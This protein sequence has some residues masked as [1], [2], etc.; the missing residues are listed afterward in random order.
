MTLRLRLF[1]SLQIEPDPGIGRLALRPRAQRLLVYLLLHRH[2][3]LRREQVAFALWPDHPEDESLGTLR[4]A[5]SD[6]RSGFPP[7]TPGDW[8]AVAHGQLRWNA[9]TEYW[10]DVECFTQ[11]IGQATPAA[12]HDA[13]ALYSGDLLTD[14][15]EEWVV[16]ERERLRQ[17]YINALRQLAAHH[18]SLGSNERALDFARRALAY[19]PLSEPLSRDLM[20]L[21]YETGDRTAALAVYERLRGLLYDELAIDPLPETQA[22]H[23]AILQ[24]APVVDREL[25]SAELAR[26]RAPPQPTPQPIG[27]GAEMQT[28]AALWQRAT[29]GAGCFALVSGA[30]GIGK[31][32]L[33]HSLADHARQGGGLALV[34]YNLNFEQ[35]LPYQPIVGMLRMAGAMLHHVELAPAHRAALG[36][37]APDILGI[38]A[39]PAPPADRA[40]HDELR[41][42]LFEALLQAFLGLARAQPLLLVFEDI[43]WAEASTIDWL[44]YVTPHLHGSRLM[45]LVT[46]RTEEVGSSH[47]LAQLQARFDPQAPITTMPLPP[48][49]REAHRDL[50]AHLSGLDRPQATAVADCLFQQSAGNP[51]FLRELVRGLL[52]TGQI[53]ARQERWSGPLIDNPTG[54]HCPVPD[55]LRTLITA[56][57]ERLNEMSRM[58]LRTAAVAGR[59]FDYELV[60]RT[61]GWAD[62]HALGALDDL[63]AREFIR[64]SE[65]PG[66][67]AFGHHLVRD[68]IYG[69]LTV[70]RR[71]YLHRR[72]AES[73]LALQPDNVAALAYHFAEGGESA[74]AGLYYLRAGDQARQFLALP[75][76][77]EYYRA[78][79]KHWPDADELG[80]AKTLVKL[81]H[82]HWVLMATR[83]A[84]DSF[85]AARIIFETRGDL[86][87]QVMVGDIERMM[88]RIYWELGDAE[89]AWAH[90][91]R[92]YALLE[93]AGE[94]VELAHTISSISQM[95][96]IASRFAEAISWGERALALAE[97]LGAEGVRI[98]ALNNV[99]YSIMFVSDR[100]VERGLVML[101]ESLRHALAADLVP[102]AC[103]ACQNLGDA[104]RGLCRY[105]EARATLDSLNAYAA[106]F[107]VPRFVGVSLCLRLGIDWITGDWS[108]A[109]SSLAATNVMYGSPAVWLSTRRGQIENDLGRAETARQELERTLPTVRGMDELQTTMPH[110]GELVRAYAALELEAQAAEIAQQILALIDRHPSL[111]PDSTR[112]LLIVCRWGAANPAAQVARDALRHL[113]RADQQF[114]SPETAAALA[115]ARGAPALAGGAW[116]DAIEQFRHA[117]ACWEAITRPY[118]QAR[119]LGDLGRALQAAGRPDA[120]QRVFDQALGIYEALARQLEDRELRRS[121]QAAPA[122]RD[123][124]AAR[125]TTIAESQAV[126]PQTIGYA[127]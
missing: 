8:I 125:A 67:Y 28:L 124:R 30:A 17:L 83:Q 98:H 51:F 74:Q 120:A 91:R 108:S 122:L 40:A 115:E 84:L 21:H 58:V 22:L 32:H 111:D 96:M 24:G 19:E 29:A 70:P 104:L 71:L 14:W 106:K 16:G 35:P 25:A 102:D 37:L 10:L 107:R 48:L 105:D 79:I 93:Q 45:V 103:R 68:I 3:S 86:A 61:G 66:V 112:P 13:V 116:P 12:L 23:T 54:C 53:V 47:A 114:R 43:H 59:V 94:T 15:D 72:L 127:A 95:Y 64:E 90:Y 117:A 49:A 89:G 118:D 77:V 99:G 101:R 6:L 85:E 55:S 123:L 69:A 46:Y 75:D 126:D 38:G 4:R 78:A 31:S 44:T 62:E 76:A 63:L 5:L 18:R 80:R 50:V 56:R 92:A 60:R 73:L 11:L 41:M 113:E 100:D 9:Q 110:L 88:G 39:S 26:R 42:R 121:F 1:D 34:G 36:Q 33:A 97:R 52:E 81:G 87:D 119:A 109:L 57:V 7:A 2:T 20:A 65:Q 82:C 27:R